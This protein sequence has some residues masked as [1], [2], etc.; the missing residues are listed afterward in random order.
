MLTASAYN[1]LLVSEADLI[2]DLVRDADD[3]R[4]AGGSPCVGWSALDV[5]RHV[6]ITPRSV[7]SHLTAHLNGLPAPSEEPLPLSTGRQEIVAGLESGSRALRT[8]LAQL[9]DAALDGDLPGPFGPLPGRSAL[10]LALTELAL[11]RCDIAI[12]LGYSTDMAPAAAHAILDV[13]QAW[14]LLVAPSSPLESPLCYLLSD[15][16]HEWRFAFDGDRWTSDECNS[17]GEMITATGKADRL[18]LALAGRIPMAEALEH[19][20]D[21]AAATKFKTYLPGP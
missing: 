3:A 4:L 15:G 21:L 10:G 1:G 5:A 19:S 6:E 16:Q 12:A 7:A 2:R 9:D 13:L 17:I 18:V 20:S 8:A 11:H 14:L